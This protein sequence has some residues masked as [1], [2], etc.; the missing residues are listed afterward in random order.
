MSN[1][2]KANRFNVSK[3]V[4]AAISK[5]DKTGYEH[6]TIKKFG[7]PMQVQ[8]TPSYATGVLYG[9]GVKQEDMSKLTGGTLKVDINKLPIEVRSEILGHKY[10]NGVLIENK[11]DQPIDIAIGYEIEQTGNHRELIWLLKGKAKPI[12]SSIQQTTDNIN[13]ST[14]SIDIG[15][16]PRD[17]NG[18]IKADGD[19]ANADF[20][21]SA[22]ESFLETIPGGTL[23]TGV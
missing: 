15:F 14:D 13:Y 1:S 3:I 11:N 4:Y 9:G 19:T 20:T 8:F 17:Y 12:G 5:D 6:G 16:M 2:V 7:E 23:V 10:E 21:N 18:D 22:A